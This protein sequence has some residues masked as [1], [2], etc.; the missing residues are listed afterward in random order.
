MTSTITAP[1]HARRQAE[2]APWAWDAVTAPIPVQ[3]AHRVEQPVPPRPATLRWVGAGA[4][5]AALLL[6]TAAGA[7]ALGHRDAAPAP[8]VVSAAPITASTTAP[9]PT[10]TAA[11]ASGPQ[12]VDTDGH[13]VEDAVAAQVRVVYTALQQ[14]DIDALRRSE[15]GAGSDDGLTSFP[16]L[17]GSTV[18]N[19]LLDALR[20]RPVHDGNTYRYRTGSYALQFVGANGP[21]GAGLATISGP[22]TSTT[23][24]SRPSSQPTTTSP[25]T[26]VFPY[27]SGPTG[28]H[29]DGC[30]PYEHNLDGYCSPDTDVL[31]EDGRPDPAR[32]V[33]PGNLE[34][35]SRSN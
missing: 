14:N 22:W 31:D 30:G 2:P 16:H 15:G 7:Y 8:A 23:S 9:V 3:V 28:R 12:L 20:T 10:T 32:A 21:L 13:A 34:N 11:V 24:S 4:L 18:R 17:A 35:P 33:V 5:A 26:N 6:G 1:R 19:R 27:G 29:G 25:S